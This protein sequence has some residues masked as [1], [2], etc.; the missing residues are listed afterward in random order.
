MFPVSVVSFCSLNVHSC[1]ICILLEEFNFDYGLRI[2]T[3]D[4][5]TLLRVIDA[6][7][8]NS[9]S[10]MLFLLSLGIVV[11]H[12]VIDFVLALGDGPFFI[13]F[14]GFNILLDVIEDGAWLDDAQVDVN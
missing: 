11:I 12:Y 13:K 9:K 3:F 8:L 5:V 1:S 14:V 4:F 7:W 6:I 10:D 2:K